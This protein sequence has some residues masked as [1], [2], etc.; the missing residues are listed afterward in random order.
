MIV[1]ILT[2]F[3]WVFV[4]VFFGIL[5]FQY[6]PT[7]TF[8]GYFLGTIGIFLNIL[9][10]CANGGRMPV[11]D[12]YLDSEDH[13]SMNSTTKLRWLGDWIN[14]GLYFHSP[15]DIFLYLSMVFCWVG[16]LVL[17]GEKL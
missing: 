14:F 8:C 6:T 17:I 13:Q 5:N 3:M 12:K 7:L 1:R 9:V 11:D 4:G 2:V 16:M 10:V 15:G